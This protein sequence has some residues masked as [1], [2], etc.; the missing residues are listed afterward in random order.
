MRPLERLAVAGLLAFMAALNLA[1]AARTSETLDESTHLDYGRRVL[2]GDPRRLSAIE[3]ST[4]P[5]SAAN[6][7][8]AAVGAALPAGSW[9]T[10]LG[11]LGAARLATVAAALA[12]ALVTWAWARRLYG[13]VAGGVALALVAFDP[14]LLAHSHLVTTDVYAALGFALAFWA[15]WRAARDPGHG[16]ALVAEGLA[17]G[18]AQL[19]KYFA[20]LAYPLT[21]AIA[22]LR[23]IRQRRRLAPA[24]GRWTLTALLSLLVI[25]AGFG[26]DR[27]LRPAESFAFRSLPFQWLAEIPGL[28]AVPV[29]LPA[30]Y[31]EGLDLSLHA[32]REYPTHGPTYLLGR[33]HERGVPGYYFVAAL[34]KVPLPVLLLGTV[35]VV[36]YLRRR[37]RFDFWNDEIY[38]LAPLVVFTLYLDFLYRSQIGIRHALAV[39]PFGYLLIATL[40]A[41]G[42]PRSRRARLGLAALAAWLVA[43]FA[44]AFP[45]YIPYFNELV[46]DR[47]LAYRILSDSNVDWGQGAGELQAW[48]RAHPEAIR[49]PPAPVAGRVVVSVN[50]LTGVVK[51]EQFAWLRPLPPAGHIAYS[52][53]VFE[54][55][56]EFAAAARARPSAG[57]P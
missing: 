40:F 25:G 38:Y 56:E 4:M 26:F 22:A 57:P 2:G 49:S 50:E 48:L 52:D 12:L 18:F 51:G 54:V 46:P 47:K 14:N 35:A 33:R 34:V 36:S 6:A 19:T 20:L 45:Y 17:L 29:P 30:A 27:P 53:L 9:R 21:A 44:A 3:N 31:V 41:D 13:A 16:R 1:V 15:A 39:F 32:E 43:S 23:A 28:R 42:W 10:R 55:S 37:R 5:V 24:L 8:P 11:S 7:L